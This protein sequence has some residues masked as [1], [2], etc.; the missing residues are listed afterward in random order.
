MKI[1]EENN[2]WFF[3][4]LSVSVCLCLCLSLSV[5]IKQPPD[6]DY[7]RWFAFA[8]PAVVKAGIWNL[9]WVPTITHLLFAKDTVHGMLDVHQLM[10]ADRTLS[11][12]SLQGRAHFV[13]QHAV[14]RA[15]IQQFISVPRITY[16]Q[17][18]THII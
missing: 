5:L 11:L 10:L 9:A 8:F 3:S 13:T 2:C 7:T 18:R 6:K 4:P 12:M 1:K 17:T 14:C 16:T 15:S